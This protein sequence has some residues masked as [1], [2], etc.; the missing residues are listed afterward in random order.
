MRATVQ[1]DGASVTILPRRAPVGASGPIRGRAL[2]VFPGTPPPSLDAPPDAIYVA[3]VGEDE[4]PGFAAIDLNEATAT[5]LAH[6]LGLTEVLYWDGRRAQ[7]LDCTP[8]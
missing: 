5:A 6:T 4:R 3:T 2:A 1:I 8:A 7:V